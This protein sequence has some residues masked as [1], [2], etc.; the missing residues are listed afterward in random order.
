VTA[1][2]APGSQTLQCSFGTG[3]LLPGDYLQIG[4]RLHRVLDETGSGPIGIWPSIREPLAGGET[5]ITNNPQ[6]LFRLGTNKR[7]WSADWIRLTHLS[8]QIQE[9]R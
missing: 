6:G 8:F 5:I 2:A 1:A 3:A 4:Y 9:Y 7:T